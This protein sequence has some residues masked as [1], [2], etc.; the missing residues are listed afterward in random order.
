[1]N[2]A[3]MKGKE[4]IGGVATANHKNTCENPVRM[5]NRYVD[6]YRV[7]ET[8]DKCQLNVIALKWFNRSSFT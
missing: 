7:E 1:M 6:K 2:S 8:R 4:K 5:S 3:Y